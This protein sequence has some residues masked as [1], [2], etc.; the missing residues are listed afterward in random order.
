MAIG[1]RHHEVV[2]E[3]PSWLHGA[4]HGQH[5]GAHGQRVADDDDEAF[6]RREPVPPLSGQFLRQRVLRRNIDFRN[7]DFRNIDFRNIDFRNIDFRNVEKNL[8]CDFS[9]TSFYIP[10]PA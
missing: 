7:I 10:D 9:S 4:L 5:A 3:D 6:S 1:I 2:Q 8:N